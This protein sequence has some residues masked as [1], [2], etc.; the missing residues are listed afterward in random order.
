MG[1]GFAGSW[2]AKGMKNRNK[3]KISKRKLE[4]IRCFRGPR[5][6]FGAFVS[7]R[8]VAVRSTRVF[9]WFSTEA[10]AQ[11]TKT[12]C[13]RVFSPGSYGFACFF[14][15]FVYQN[16]PRPSPMCCRDWGG[17]IKK[18]EYKQM[19]S[20]FSEL[21]FEDFGQVSVRIPI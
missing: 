13:F 8:D 2:G 3:T 10:A 12:S 1:E 6:R 15:V 9:S 14:A 20:K 7:R 5:C 18:K 21:V 11:S 16:Q 17:V 19:L 4:E